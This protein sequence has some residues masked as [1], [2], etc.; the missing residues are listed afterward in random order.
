MMYQD[1]FDKIKSLSGYPLFSVMKQSRGKNPNIFLACYQRAK[2]LIIPAG[3]WNEAKKEFETLAFPTSLQA[4][5]NV[6]TSKIK[7]YTCQISQTVTETM[8]VRSQIMSLMNHRTNQCVV[9]WGIRGGEVDF[10]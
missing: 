10:N 5:F 6:K 4:G 1:L 8:K 3:N 9:R 2:E 7:G